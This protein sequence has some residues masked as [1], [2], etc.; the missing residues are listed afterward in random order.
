MGLKNTFQ[1]AAQTVL[2]A[3]GD[4][5]ETASLFKASSD[6]PVYN[7]LTASPATAGT[8]Y[9]ISQVMYYNFAV[10]QIDNEKVL[11]TDEIAMIPSLNI[12]VIPEVDDIITKADTSEWKIVNL[13]PTDPAKAL[14]LCH[15]RRNL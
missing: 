6:K 10:K 13:L 12:T 2:A 7:P 4:V 8:S 1:T 5:G 3:F 15:I 14:W 9:T 11:P